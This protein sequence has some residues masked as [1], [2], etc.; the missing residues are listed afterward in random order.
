MAHYFLQI[1]L[2]CLTWQ[3]II[4]SSPWWAHITSL[5]SSLPLVPSRET[6]LGPYNKS[7]IFQSFSARKRDSAELLQTMGRDKS[8]RLCCLQF[9][10]CSLGLEEWSA[11]WWDCPDIPHE[12]LSNSF[13]PVLASQASLILSTKIW[14]ISSPLSRWEKEGIAKICMDL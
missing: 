3:M 7:P 1:G 2:S 14:R 9:S 4:P 13:T 10:F 8:P 11:W 6:S 5:F 12:A